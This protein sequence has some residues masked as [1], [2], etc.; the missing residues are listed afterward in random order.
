MT[1]SGDFYCTDGAVN[2][3]TSTND[4]LGAKEDRQ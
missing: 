3:M 4:P 1:H 2:R